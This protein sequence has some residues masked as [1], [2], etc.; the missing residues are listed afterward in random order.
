MKKIIVGKVTTRSFWNENS[1]T[2]S[3]PLRFYDYDPMSIVVECIFYD[4]IVNFI[5]LNLI[6]IPTNVCHILYM[7]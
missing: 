2:L 4:M 5:R 1:L 7:C 3:D 6:G